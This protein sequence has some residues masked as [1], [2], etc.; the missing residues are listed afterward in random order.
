M[1]TFL[2]VPADQP[3]KLE[4][5][6]RS[7]ADAVLAD[8]ED[9]VAASSKVTA[10]D[11]LREWL[12][13]LA[14]RG[15]PRPTVW[16]RVNA[17][18]T[19]DDLAVGVHPAVAGICLPKAETA[20]QVQAFVAELATAEARQRVGGEPSAVMLMI[21]TARGVLGAVEVASASDRV[22]LLQLGEQDLNADLG[23]P[24]RFDAGIVS[25]PIR[26]ARDAVVLASA[27][28]RLLA[29]IGPVSTFIHDA[30]ALQQESN[31]LRRNGF[32]GRAAIH[33][34]QLAPVAAGFAPNAE[35]RAWAERVVAANDDA[36]AAGSGVTLVDGR[37]VDAPVVEQARRLLR[38][39]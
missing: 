24:P 39:A 21:E 9:G 5:A 10:R 31:E 29:P 25:S 19:A 22:T 36:A 15:G 30:D 23:L 37:M 32:G 20:E 3:N 38:H 34:A 11:T 16:V 17:G 26:A 33:P 4:K 1:T 8:L 2:Y 13:S 6:L 18:T 14:D 7:N 35:E 28:A 27:A 12:A